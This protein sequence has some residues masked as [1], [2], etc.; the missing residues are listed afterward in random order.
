VP[1]IRGKPGNDHQGAG[2]Q[3]HQDDERQEQ[4]TPRTDSHVT[5]GNDPSLR[6]TGSHLVEILHDLPAV[7]TTAEMSFDQ[8]RL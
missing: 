3:S 7:G 1:G 6:I 5:G 8:G 2:A 4:A